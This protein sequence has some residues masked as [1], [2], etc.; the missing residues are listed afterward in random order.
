MIESITD[1]LSVRIDLPRDGIGDGC[2]RIASTDTVVPLFRVLPILNNL[3]LRAIDEHPTRHETSAGTEVRRYDLTVLVPPHI[4]DP[5]LAARL[6]E[7]FVATWRGDVADDGLHRLILDAGLSHSQIRVVRAYAGYLRQAGLPYTSGHLETV[8][9]GHGAVVRR[10][11]ELFEARFDPDSTSAADAADRAAAAAVEAVAGIDADRILRSMLTALR[12]TTRTNFYCGPRTT[13]SLKLEAARIDYLPAPR[14]QFET[15]VHGVDVHGTHLR[16]DRI[17]RGGLRW[18]T[19]PDDFRTEIL[20]LVTAQ[21]VKNA[22]IVPAGAKGGFVVTRPDP[23]ADHVRACYREFVSALLDLTDNLDPRTGR[24]LPAPGV[25]RHDSADTYLVV[26]ADKGTATFSDLANAVAVERGY[27][28]GDAFAS[29]GAV[30]YDHK[31]MGIT[32][33]GAWESARRHLRELHIDPDSDPFTVV[34]V[35]DMSGDVFGNGMLCSPHIRLVAAFDH[36]H[37]F[38]DPRPDPQR[39]YAERQRLFALPRSS[40]ADYDPAALGAGAIVVERTAKA[41]PLTTQARE[42]LGLPE[43]VTTLSADELVSA[44][45]RA[46]VDLMWNGGVGT[47]VK[48]STESHL[49][50]GDKANDAVRVD[51]DTVRARVVVEGGN[52]GLTQRGRIEFARHGGHVNTDALD[53]SA[54]VHC[55]DYEVNIKIALDNNSADAALPPGERRILLAR[56]T[57]AVADAVLAQNRRQNHLMGANRLEAARMVGFHAQ[58]VDALEREGIA[59]RTVDRLPSAAEFARRA[60]RG[61]GLT[62][63]E[64]AQLTALVK[65]ALRR[66]VLAGT[67][68]D[69]PV[70]APRLQRYFPAALL[71]DHADAVAAHPLRREIVTS[72]LVNDL[73]DSA[74]ATFVARL[75]SDTAADVADCVRAFEA[76]TAIFGLDD[77]FHTIRAQDHIPVAAVDALVV[78]AQRLLDRAARW[79]VLQRALPLDVVAETARYRPV[80][81]EHAAAVRG[82]LRGD[83]IDAVR[84]RT[85]DLVALGAPEPL[86]ARVADLLHVFCFLDIADLA[87]TAGAPRSQ[88]RFG[89][90]AELYFATSA[91]LHINTHLTA[92]SGLDRRDRWQ[93]LARLSL[94]EELYAALR[95]VV[96]GLASTPTT[97]PADRLRSWER[98]HAGKLHAAR[99]ILGEAVNGAAGGDL[100]G[101]AGLTRMC[102]ATRQ[103]RVMSR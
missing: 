56:M 74:G 24:E 12:A 75:Q 7:A 81:R 38:V 6:E 85:A 52:L 93:A 35:G 21:A 72:S 88:G 2:V 69:E 40:W 16:F 49:D 36:R 64:L 92:V 96:G 45:L 29:G 57:D 71:V 63:P 66:D 48:A 76:V 68:P 78:Q 32:A 1:A 22:V 19:R 59:D 46:P 17:A 9:A 25:V 42:A 86:A 62:S 28:L 87:A 55:S 83:E 60:D 53:N 90:V 34:G 54:G 3:G 65:N 77:V 14:P 18:S 67:V 41:V 23:D 39:A 50:C 101:T 11:T 94:R 43:T 73:V 97:E 15:F 100:S 10:L 61:E 33:R 20:G 98:A 70:S 102:V 51:A 82:W 26:A 27:W 30:G 58:M 31:K 84:R 95:G 89:D 99:R 37:V 13:L 80:V 8:L 91:H 103:L 47:F 5:T 79:F 44:V 4:P